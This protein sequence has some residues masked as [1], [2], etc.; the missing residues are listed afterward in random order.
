[1]NNFGSKDAELR[2]ELSWHVLANVFRSEHFATEKRKEI[3]AQLLTNEFLFFKIE[4]GESDDSVRRSFSVLNLADLISGDTKH[5]QSFDQAFLKEINHSLRSY[6]LKEKDFRGL[7]DALG[8]IHCIAHA[9]DAFTAVCDHPNVDEK[10]LVENSKA[11]LNF[12]KSQEHN[13]FRWEENNRLGWSISFLI[14]KLG[15]E[16]FSNIF[17]Q[18]IPKDYIYEKPYA[19]N[20]QNTM[21]CA[22]IDTYGDEP[23]DIKALDKI[24]ELF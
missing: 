4:N 15:I 24:K 5:S 6:L 17:H 23:R 1:M 22:F 10:D 12:I 14:D 3:A 11:I 9:A 18:E 8:W 21:R 19:Q 7:V 13:V 16:K 2:D 20:L